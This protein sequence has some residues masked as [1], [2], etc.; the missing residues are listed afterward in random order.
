MYYFYLFIFIFKLMT[1]YYTFSHDPSADNP[2]KTR[3]YSIIENDNN[4][5]DDARG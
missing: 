3:Y 4:R 2:S 5:G 1:E